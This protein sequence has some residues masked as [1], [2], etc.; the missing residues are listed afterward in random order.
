LV[1]H[2]LVREA[3][4]SARAY[5]AGDQRLAAYIVPVVTSSPLLSGENKPADGP[6]IS[7]EEVRTFL[8]QSLPDYMVPSTLVF[9]EQLPRTPNGKVD[10]NALPAPDFA[11]L[12]QT[13]HVAPRTPVE[14]GLAAI[15]A[16]VLKLERVGV[17]DDF[18]ELGGHS[19]LA[20]Q[21]LSRVRAAFG[22]ELPFRVLF[23]ATTVV[24]LAK[25]VEVARWLESGPSTAPPSG[26][27]EYEDFEI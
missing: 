24:S 18:F 20:T 23:E 19:L 21:I 7:T 4:V 26:S 9:L 10:C 27:S 15:W 13:C 17:E 8:K 2:P 3:V 22:V 6:D 12:P 25:A 1:E 14:E 16:E 11:H 5:G